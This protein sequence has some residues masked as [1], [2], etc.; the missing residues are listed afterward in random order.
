[1]PPG[2][3]HADVGVGRAAVRAAVVVE[4]GHWR[5]RRPLASRRVVGGSG[6][7]R[8]VARQPP[9]RRADAPDVSD[10]A[11]QGSRVQGSR[12]RCSRL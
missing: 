7:R 2:R 11:A 5:P 6:R 3:G 10:P 12:L 4:L 1:M 8:G 9:A